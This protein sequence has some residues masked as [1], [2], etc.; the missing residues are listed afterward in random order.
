MV[1]RY[2]KKIELCKD[3]SEKYCQLMM[4]MMMMMMMMFTNCTYFP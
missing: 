1:D 3:N 2:L 4:M